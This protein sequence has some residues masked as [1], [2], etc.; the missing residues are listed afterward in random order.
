[1]AGL[2]IF[3]R[4]RATASRFR[5]RPT[6]ASRG[7]RR[8]ASIAIP[9]VQ[10]F[11]PT[12]TIRDDGTIGVTYY[13]FRNNTSDPTTLPTDLWL[14]AVERRRRPGARATFPGRSTCPSHRCAQGLF[15]GD[16]H[17]LTSIGATFVPF[18]VQTNNGNLANR[19]D[20]FASLVNSPGTAAKAAPRR[21]AE[22]DRGR[23]AA[24]PGSDHAGTASS[25]CR[26]PRSAC[27]I[28]AGFGHGGVRR[29]PTVAPGAGARDAAARR[30]YSASATRVPCSIARLASS[31]SATSAPPISWCADAAP[32]RARRPARAAAPGRRRSRS[33]RR[34]A[35]RGLPSTRDVQ[36]GVV[37]ALVLDAGEH[38]HAALLEQRAADPAGRLGE[39]GADLRVL[40]LQQPHLARRRR[41]RA[42]ACRPPRCAYVGVDAP[43]VA[44]RGDRGIVDARRRSRVRPARRPR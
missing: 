28:C 30:I 6:A 23:E 22:A 37:D 27:S 18:Y 26:R 38:R 20:V 32:R 5:A 7:P 13:D 39:A 10:A 1:M 41:A 42:A 8:F 44:E 31:S 43:L 17:A 24:P 40:A 4:D 12:V 34:R 35:A 9:A 3:R 33:C 2:A 11:S 29:P 25:A 21:R 19:T 15:L 14:D 16:Y 36:P